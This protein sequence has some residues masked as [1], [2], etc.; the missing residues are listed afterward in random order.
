MEIP[1]TVNSLQLFAP[2][3]SN[4]N[5]LNEYYSYI[6]TPLESN[7]RFVQ[8]SSGWKTYLMLWY[9]TL[10]YFRESSFTA[11]FSKKMLLVSK[12]NKK[13]ERKT[14]GVLPRGRT[15]EPVA[16]PLSS[17]DRSPTAG[18]WC[19]MPSVL[20][21]AVEIDQFITACTQTLHLTCPCQSWWVGHTFDD[22][23]LPLLSLVQSHRRSPHF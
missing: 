13:N 19:E 10:R 2:I 6:W 17:L 7:G 1:W 11:C 3:Y 12:L 9:A 23:K 15:G 8:D 4:E 21:M 18:W 16:T 14:K 22:R 20:P 5:V